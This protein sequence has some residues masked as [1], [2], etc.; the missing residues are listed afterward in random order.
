MVVVESETGEKP[1][2]CRAAWA[3]NSEAETNLFTDV[4]YKGDLKMLGPKALLFVPED[5]LADLK[6]TLQDYRPFIEQFTAHHES[7]F[8]CFD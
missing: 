3:R 6:K 5:N 2:I 7:C 8:R 1:A 4:F